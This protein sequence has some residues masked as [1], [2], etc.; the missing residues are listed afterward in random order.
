M[1]A[2]KILKGVAFVMS[3]AP[4]VGK[5]KEGTVKNGETFMENTLAITSA[6]HVITNGEGLKS[7]TATLTYIYDELYRLTH[8]IYGLIDNQTL[9][10][11][12]NL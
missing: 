3:S 7:A 1:I 5:P 10:V 11:L 4:I 9:P 6:V 12:I 2:N 8:M